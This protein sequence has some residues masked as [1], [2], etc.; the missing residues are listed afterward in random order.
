MGDNEPIR[1]FVFRA[2]LCFNWRGEVERDSKSRA[3]GMA[4]PG[5]IFLMKND[6]F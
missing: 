5:L 1:L 2:A 4:K 3:F 6:N